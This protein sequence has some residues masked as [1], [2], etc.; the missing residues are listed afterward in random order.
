MG[1]LVA[2]SV[3]LLLCLGTG[4]SAR[5]DRPL[6]NVEVSGGAGLSAYNSG[7]GSLLAPPHVQLQAAY[8]LVRAGPLIMGPSLALPVGFFSPERSDGGTAVQ[9]ALRPGWTVYGRPTVDL[10]WSVS[11]G[12]SFVVTPDFVWGLELG[13]ALDYFVTA[14]LALTV[15][16]DYGFF[17]GVDPVHVFTGRLG[18]L[19]SWEA[20]W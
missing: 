5:A 1:R 9:L 14:G 19:I 10:G 17:Y 8:L 2:T 11:A 12:P 3:A 18:L 16:L 13:G 15:G 20:P 4:S 7:S 6:L